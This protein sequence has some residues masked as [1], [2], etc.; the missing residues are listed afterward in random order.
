MQ[1]PPP[2]LSARP[3]HQVPA[4]ASTVAGWMLS[5]WP[6]WYGPGG[7][8]D[9]AGDVA[10]FGRS[11][12]VLPVGFVVFSGEQAI[13]FGALKRESIPSQAHL[14]PWAAAG[15]VLPSHRGQ[16]VGAFLLQAMVSHAQQLG[17]ARVYCGTSTAASLLQRA[18][19]QCLAQIVHAG[20]PMGIYVSGG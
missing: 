10:A 19:W 8:G 17:H 20:Q 7:P 5:E 15:F 16:G 12:V 3:L 4:L 11:D 2:M 13:G 1:P 6:Q 9:L 14:S 18:G